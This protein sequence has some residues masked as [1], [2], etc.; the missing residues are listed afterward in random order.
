MAMK[1]SVQYDLGDDLLQ[2]CSRMTGMEITNSP[3]EADAVLFGRDAEYGP[4]TKVFQCLFAGSDHLSSDSFPANSVVLSNAGAYSEPVAETV[5][6]LILSASKKICFH[7][8]D[9]HQLKYKR[10]SV[11]TLYG[12]SIGILGF[13][14]I[15]KKVAEIA[16]A[17]SMNVYSYTTHPVATEKV[18]FLE[19]P[20]AL[21]EKCSVVV[22]S[23]PLNDRTRGFVN[24]DLLSVFSGLM[25]VNIARADIVDRNDMLDFLDRN[26]SRY[27]LTD[28]WWNEPD[29][30]GPIPDNCLVTPHIGGMGREFL[31]TAVERA[32]AN[33]KNYVDGNP[34]NVIYT[35]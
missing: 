27:F 25:I 8:S 7:N 34:H 24:K 2:V 13:G 21:F 23:T 32:C 12:K 17:F 33:L 6:G 15:G 5:F 35:K 14:G 20:K 3:S 10:R 9:F 4:S 16:S 31:Q 18:T 19:S 29:I 28:V 1:L 26:P 22:I 11:R 30:S